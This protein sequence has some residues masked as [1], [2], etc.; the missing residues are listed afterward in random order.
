MGGLICEMGGNVH[1]EPPQK[2]HFLCQ[3]F[4]P[5]SFHFTTHFYTITKVIN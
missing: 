2:I 5:T 4:F 1:G 3:Y